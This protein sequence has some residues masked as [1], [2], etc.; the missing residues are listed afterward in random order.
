M[1]E[2]SSSQGWGMGRSIGYTK[3]IGKTVTRSVQRSFTDIPPTLID[4]HEEFSQEQMDWLRGI[5]EELFSD[6]AG[7]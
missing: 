6:G 3:T 2:Q 4:P 5:N 7:I 1:Q